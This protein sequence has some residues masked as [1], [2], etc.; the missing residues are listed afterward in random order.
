MNDKIKISSDDKK[1]ELKKRL[2]NE[3]WRRGDL[4]YKFHSGQKKIYEVLN[5]LPKTSRE[6]LLFIAR[7][8]GKSYF[9]ALLAIMAAKRRF[10]TKVLIMGP[11][12]KQTKEIMNPIFKKIKVDDYNGLL[13]ETKSEAKWKIGSSEIQLA[14]F[15]TCIEAVRGQE[16]GLIIL[17]EP[18][19][20]KI[21]KEE[22]EYIVKSILWP[23][24]MHTKGKIFYMTTASKYADHPLH[25]LTIPKTT[26]L[27]TFFKLTIYDNPYL[28]KEEIDQEIEAMGGLDNPAVRREL[29]C[30][31][32]RD[33]T[34]LAIPKFNIDK[35]VKE[36]DL[37]DHYICWV[38]GDFGGV[39]D[40]TVAHL[41]AYDFMR[42]KKLII[43]EAV[44]DRN[45]SSGII[46]KEIKDMEK[47]YGQSN[48]LRF[49]DCPGQTQIDLQNEHDFTVIAPKKKKG[50][51]EM[52]INQVNLACETESIEIHPRCHFTITTLEYGQL[53]KPRNDFERSEDL[54]HC[55]ALASMAYGIRHAQVTNP[56]PSNYKYKDIPSDDLF[57]RST[58]NTKHP[59][60][61]LVEE[62]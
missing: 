2:I 38:A 43:D 19:S 26:L 37:P 14:G 3:L 8:W 44:F 17:E 54:G 42:G 51:F 6:V 11:T 55:D 32:V 34:H 27:G 59:L 36:F 62:E 25:T 48:L 21:N 9:G 23:T 56:F 52:G 30:E 7:R 15:D 18:G 31:I 33:E 29:L 57:I 24:L 50:S 53:N 46:A 35:N 49:M 58:S 45:T 40:K 20:A 22:Y 4:S 12:E 1:T 39:R 28:T 5:S 41:W 47:K 61:K 13:T 16:Y 10:F 60:I